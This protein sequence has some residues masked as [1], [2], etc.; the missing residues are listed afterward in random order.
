MIVIDKQV[1]LLLQAVLFVCFKNS[2]YCFAGQRRSQQANALKTALLCKRIGGGLVVWE[3][4]I[5]PQIRIRGEANLH[6]SSKLVFVLWPG[7]LVLVVLLSRVK[8]ASSS[9]SPLS[10]FYYYLIR[11]ENMYTVDLKKFM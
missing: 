6:P 5:G 9:R 1:Q 8:N 10:S 3:W 2:F 4:K 7:G 11:R